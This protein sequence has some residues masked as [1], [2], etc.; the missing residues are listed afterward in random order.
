MKLADLTRERAKDRR[1]ERNSR[2][3]L[4]RARLVG[5][6]AAGTE[7][8]NVANCD[9]DIDFFESRRWNSDTATLLAVELV[10]ELVPHLVP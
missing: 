1:L 8:G 4:R 5:W 2:A 6:H 3:L 9:T 10:R 7:Y